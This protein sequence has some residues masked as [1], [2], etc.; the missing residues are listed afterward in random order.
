MF[1]RMF[2]ARCCRNSFR[3][4][5]ASAPTSDAS[6]ADDLQTTD[7]GAQDGELERVV[8]ASGSE[9]LPV[10][11]WLAVETVMRR[12]DIVLIRWEHVDLKHR[13]AHLPATKNGGARDVPLS[14]R[15][16][17]VLQSLKEAI[18]HVKD[19]S[20][21]GEEAGIGRVF[22]I[23]SDAVTR[24]FERAVTLARKLHLEECETAKQRPDGKFLTDLRP[25]DL[26]HE[27]TSS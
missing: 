5:A 12:G 3:T 19:K 20:G 16:V 8:T 15:A 10:I 6:G 24:A 18:S 7:R 9:L 22:E 14:S 1:R 11:I 21:E 2:R 25:H 4:L 13:V 23:R 27:A 26:R 17:A